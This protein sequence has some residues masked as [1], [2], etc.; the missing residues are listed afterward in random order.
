M[1]NPLQQF[2]E[3]RPP[4]NLLNRI[5]QQGNSIVLPIFVNTILTVLATRASLAALLKSHNFSTS[6]MKIDN[7][8]YCNAE[9]SGSWYAVYQQ[10]GDMFYRLMIIDKCASSALVN[11]IKDS[12]SNRTLQSEARSL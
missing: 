5:N 7:P 2:P 1:S 11:N 6:K 8:Y 9:A 4:V 10:I 3:N 12:V